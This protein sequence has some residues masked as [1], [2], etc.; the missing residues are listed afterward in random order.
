M[1]EA[2]SVTTDDNDSLIQHYIFHIVLKK[3]LHV[4]VVSICLFFLY[5]SSNF[6]RYLHCNLYISHTRAAVLFK[7]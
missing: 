7:Q 3:H 5:P 2:G 1:D 4:F 6:W